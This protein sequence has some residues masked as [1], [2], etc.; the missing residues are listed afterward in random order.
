MIFVFPIS[1][2]LLH[3]F[4][5]QKRAIFLKAAFFYFSSLLFQVPSLNATMLQ[6]ALSRNVT[7]RNV[8]YREKQ[9]PT[10][11]KVTSRRFT[12]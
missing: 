1:V 5:D 11:G 6:V 7:F 8:T 4:A 9:F 12:T 10:D 2:L 3:H